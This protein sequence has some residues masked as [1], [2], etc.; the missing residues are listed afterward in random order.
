MA[1][2]IAAWDISPN[3]AHQVQY[4]K[5][6]VFVVG[7]VEEVLV[8]NRQKSLI[9]PEKDYFRELLPFVHA[10]DKGSFRCLSSHPIPPGHQ[11]RQ[12]I[13]ELAQKKYSGC[14]LG[15]FIEIGTGVALALFINEWTEMKE[16]LVA[17]NPDLKQR[18]VRQMEQVRSLLLQNLSETPIIQWFKNLII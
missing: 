11:M 12:I 7:G 13:E 14:F 3:T 5:E 10:Q 1:R 4:L 9:G 2:D 18:V 6:E 8:V 15:H 17:K 16:Q